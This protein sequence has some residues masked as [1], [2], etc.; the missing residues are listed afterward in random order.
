MK[1]THFGNDNRPCLFLP[2]K[3]SI[4]SAFIMQKWTGYL[5]AIEFY[6]GILEVQMLRCLLQSSSLFLTPSDLSTDTQ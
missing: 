5:H 6:T 4:L 2:L 1:A 3:R